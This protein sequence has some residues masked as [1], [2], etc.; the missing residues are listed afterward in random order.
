METRVELS[1]QVVR[2]VARQAPEPRR[3]LRTALR[4]LARNVATFAPSKAHYRNII[5]CAS[6][7]TWSSSNIGFLPS[8][9]AFNAFSRSD[10]AP[11]MSF[12][13]D[14]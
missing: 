1:E 12:L 13:N 8:D 3:V 9:A 2:F 11:S 14:S 6:A 7:V 5:G 4:G 10:A